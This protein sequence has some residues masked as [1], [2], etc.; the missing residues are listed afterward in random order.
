MTIAQ[1]L[2]IA[3]SHL[4]SYTTVEYASEIVAAADDGLVLGRER[5][6][7][8][9][10]A[11]LQPPAEHPETP[12]PG[13]NRPRD[14]ST[15]LEQRT[16]RLPPPSEVV[17]SWDSTQTP[18]PSQEPQSHTIRPTTYTFSTLSFNSMLLLPPSDATDTRPLYHV[19]VAH[20]CFMP[21][22]YITT[23]RKGGTENWEFVGDSE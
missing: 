15:G 21:L 22:S 16:G 13:F 14:M 6:P 3:H 7:R 5:T 17:L 12:F 1:T 10:P 9:T 19:S 2:T 4:S 20:N 18:A 23:V 8:P 11:S